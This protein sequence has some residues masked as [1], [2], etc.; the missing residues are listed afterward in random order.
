[1][2]SAEPKTVG[3]Y[4]GSSPDC[5]NQGDKEHRVTNIKKVTSGSTPGAAALVG[6]LYSE[7][8]AAGTQNAP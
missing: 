3:F 6:A 4:A 2:G 7:T 1:M 5:I 8:L